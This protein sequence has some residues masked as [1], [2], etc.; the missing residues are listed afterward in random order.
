MQI[1][2]R[3]E[4]SAGADRQSTACRPDCHPPV[5]R[6]GRYHGWE[7]SV[8]CPLRGG[9]EATVNWDWFALLACLARTISGC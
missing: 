3:E 5:R 4:A 6:S 8:R 1:P 9:I 7:S 2:G